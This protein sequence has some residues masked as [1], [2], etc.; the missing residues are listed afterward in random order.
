MRTAPT[1]SIP[2]KEAFDMRKF[3][4]RLL[5]V[6][7]AALAL[8]ACHKE[9]K[10]EQ[11]ATASKTPQAAV[12]SLIQDLKAVDL[13]QL[14]QHAMPPDAYQQLRADWGKDRD[15]ALAEITD[16]DRARFKKQMQ[17]FTEP[18]A[19]KKLFAKLQPTLENWE[20]KG[21][22]RLPM[23]VGIFRIMA[24]TK[25]T[26]AKNMSAEQKSQARGVLDALATWAQNTDWGD[27]A[28]AKQAVG[29][30]VDTARALDL[31]S[32]DQAYSLTYE[33]AMQRYATAWKGAEQLLEV[34]G[35]SVNTI[36]DSAKVKTL[37]Q[38]GDTATV[39]VDYTI[40]G[41]PMTSNLDMVRKDKRWYLSDVIKSW[42]KRQAR[43]AHAGSAASTASVAPAA[44]APAAA[45][46]APAAGATTH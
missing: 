29:I 17:E 39:E 28:K 16:A 22:Q 27:R 12:Q 6:L 38:K 9:D 2:Y 1:L 31:K 7:L 20:T 13:D 24:G 4:V 30:V 26:Q 5:V 32:L 40:L 23:M 21:K 46:S 36:L 37:E 19:K 44:S 33:Q 41:K 18:D 11:L 42:Q 35:L 15:K 34:Y 45:A 10:Q 14:A 25:I 8:A 43:L 3:S